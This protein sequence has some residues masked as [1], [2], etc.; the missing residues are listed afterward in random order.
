[1][2]RHSSA[3]VEVRMLG[4]KDAEQTEKGKNFRNDRQLAVESHTCSEATSLSDVHETLVE[5]TKYFFISYNQAKGKEFKVLR[6]SNAEHARKLIESGIE[7]FQKQSD[8]K[9]D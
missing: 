8:S 7:K 1:M 5:Q 2:N 4:F 6:R 3:A 9:P